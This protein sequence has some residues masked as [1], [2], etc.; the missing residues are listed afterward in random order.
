[1]DYIFKFNIKSN[2]IQK[3]SV[4]DFLTNTRQYLLITDTLYTTNYNNNINPNNCKTNIKKYIYYNNKGKQIYTD[5]EIFLYENNELNYILLQFVE[6]YYVKAYIPYK[7]ELFTSTGIFSDIES[8]SY[9]FNASGDYTIIAK[10]KQPP[11]NY[12]RTSNVKGYDKSMD[13]NN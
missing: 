5:F 7:V 8:V 9:E 13:N 10:A 4:E 12:I 6:N 11:I 3:N 2:I 1:M